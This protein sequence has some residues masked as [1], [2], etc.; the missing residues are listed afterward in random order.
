MTASAAKAAIF[1]F[2]EVLVNSETI[3]LAELQDCFV[4]DPGDAVNT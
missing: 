4:D 3:A 2:D 1:D